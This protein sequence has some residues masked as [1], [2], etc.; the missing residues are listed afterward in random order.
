MI[1][2]KEYRALKALRKGPTPLDKKVAN[3]LASLG[4]VE[5]C[6]FTAERIH[7]GTNCYDL[8][9]TIEYKL[10]EAGESEI[11]SFEKSRNDPFKQIFIA[12]ASGAILLLI[13]AVAK[14]VLALMDGAQ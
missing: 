8:A 13:P 3:R 7:P 5:S 1:N 2:R 11:R 6:N 12:V 10:T 4:Y 14:F 9:I